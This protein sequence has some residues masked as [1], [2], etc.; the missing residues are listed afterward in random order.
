MLWFDVDS[1]G[2][3]E[4]V[5]EQQENTDDELDD[6]ADH[7][8]L[9]PHNAHVEEV[10]DALTTE[11]FTSTTMLEMQ[12]Q[13]A[14][15]TREEQ[16]AAANRT[17]EEQIAFEKARQFQLEQD[18]LEEA[19]RIEALELQRQEGERRDIERRELLLKQQL[20]E[21]DEEEVKIKTLA[22]SHT[23]EWTYLK[24]VLQAKVF[25]NLCVDHDLEYCTCTNRFKLQQESEDVFI[26]VPDARE[27]SPPPNMDHRRTRQSN[28]IQKS[29]STTWKPQPEWVTG[30][31]LT[32]D[33][34]C[35]ISWV[36]KI[37]RPPVSPQLSPT[38]GNRSRRRRKNENQKDDA[39]S[40]S[41]VQLPAISRISSS[42]TSIPTAIIRKR[43]TSPTAAQASAPPALKAQPDS[44]YQLPPRVL[45]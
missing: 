43:S 7:R 14:R 32:N 13:R 23:R 44:P 31:A 30:G 5:L 42:G 26:P 10:L 12:Q 24:P 33:K 2:L 9:S 6:E 21:N 15:T 19:A 20:E 36:K 28:I 25:H 39:T 34:L 37:A 41:G 22:Y 45:S 17:I 35:D 38:R 11:C 40:S 8:K 4:E 27:R 16:E 3:M 29:H 1:N 18:A